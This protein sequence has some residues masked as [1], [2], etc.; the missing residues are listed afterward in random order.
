MKN[1]M[2]PMIYC[3]LTLS[4]LA[5]GCWTTE[6]EG[7]ESVVDDEDM[8]ALDYQLKYGPW[9]IEGKPWPDSK[10]IWLN[11]VADGELVTSRKIFEA[12]DM[13]GDGRV[14]MVHRLSKT[15]EI[16]ESAYDFDLDGDIDATELGKP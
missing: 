7:I 1:R 5:A 3:S 10:A 16:I 4:I 12:F 15:G 8:P 13:N 2:W 9:V 6:K 14:D 11:G